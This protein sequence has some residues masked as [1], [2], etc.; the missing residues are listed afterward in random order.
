M[1]AQSNVSTAL[2]SLG[3]ADA[4]Q[5][6]YRVVSSDGS[7]VIAKAMY[8]SKGCVVMTTTRLKNQDGSY[9]ISEA[10][11]F[12]PDVRIDPDVNGGHKLVPEK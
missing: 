12:V 5:I 8:V 3:N 11:A 6:L 1:A 2:P 7:M 4:F 10:L 9:A